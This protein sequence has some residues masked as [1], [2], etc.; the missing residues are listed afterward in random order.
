MR[1][2]PD[3]GLNMLSESLC[4]PYFAEVF[5][6]HLLAKTSVILDFFML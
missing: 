3:E 1:I 6:G 5:S 4:K 2:E